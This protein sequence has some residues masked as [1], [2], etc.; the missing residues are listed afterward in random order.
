MWLYNSRLVE[1][2]DAQAPATGEDMVQ[3]TP[4]TPIG[5]IDD[6]DTTQLTYDSILIFDFRLQAW[7]RWTLGNSATYWVRDLIPMP[8]SFL[9]DSDLRIKVICQAK[10]TNT[11]KVCEFN[12]VTTFRDNGA[13]TEAFVA[14][15]PDSVQEPDKLKS[16]PYVHVFMRNNPD[17]SLKMQARWDWARGTDSGKIT[18]WW[19]VYRETRPGSSASGLI[20]TK[21]KVAGRGRNLFLVFK[22]YGDKPCWFDGWTTKFDASMRI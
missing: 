8:N 4:V 15:G 3:T 18:P 7:T 1:P 10:N 5:V 20:V 22:S 13:S 17:S 2:I 11:F 19:E 6:S 12:D 9:S 14:S 16:A 21:N